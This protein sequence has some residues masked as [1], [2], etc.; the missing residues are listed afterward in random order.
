VAWLYRPRQI[1]GK[2]GAGLA[3]VHSAF[4]VAISLPCVLKFL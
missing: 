2:I 3:A 4:F 1:A